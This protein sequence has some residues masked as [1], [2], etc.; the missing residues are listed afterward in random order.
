MTRRNTSML[1]WM[2]SPGR[3]KNWCARAV[4]RAFFQQP[5]TNLNVFSNVKGI[6]TG[7]GLT[8]GN[9]EFWPNN[10]APNNTAKVP[11]ASDSVYDF[12]DAPTDPLDGYGSMQLH[13]HDARQTMFAINDWGPATKPIS[14]SAT[15][16]RATRT[17]LSPPMRAPISTNASACWSAPDTAPLP[18]PRP[19]T[20]RSLDTEIAA[21][22]GP[23]RLSRLVSL[24]GRRRQ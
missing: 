2:P 10:Y 20:R 7:S 24:P 5:V 1:P 12:G 22:Q 19:Q 11:N 8:G 4:H 17:G 9:I 14:A 13:N 3:R 6:V 16:P 18:P 15:S 21:R 23:V